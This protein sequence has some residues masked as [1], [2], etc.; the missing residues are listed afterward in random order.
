MRLAL[1]GASAAATSG[2]RSLGTA[3]APLVENITRL[4]P[5]PVARVVRP[6]D[7]A[8]ICEALA[9]WPGQ[10]SVGGAR[11][12]MGGQIAL[13]D[14]L[15]LDMRSMRSLISLDP[16]TRRARVQAGMRWRDLQDHLDPLGLAVRTMQ[17]YANFTVGGSV[18]VNAHGRYVGHGPIGHSIRALRIVLADGRMIEADR[19]SNSDLFFAAIGGYGALGVIAEVELELDDNSRIERQVAYIPLAEYP[20]WFRERVLPD[21][22]VVLHN[23]DLYPGRF[24]AGP[25]ITWRRSQ[26]PLTIDARL[27][28]DGAKYLGQRSAI[29]AVTELPGGGAMRKHIIAPAQ[30]DHPEVVWRNY[31]ASLDIESLEPFSR[32]MSTYALEEYFVPVRH[33][34]AFL[35]EL[36]R[37]LRKHD[38]EALNVSIRHSPADTESVMA[39]AREEVFC[40]VIYYK[41]RVLTES[42]RR[43]GVWTRQ[44]IDAATAHGGSYY[45]PYQLHATPEQFAAAYPRHAEFRAIKDRYDPTGRFSN[46]MWKK[47]LAGP[48]GGVTRRAIDPARAACTSRSASP[49]GR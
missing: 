20:G 23:V 14:S 24:D 28:P 5:V 32:F 45:L 21:P 7:S 41:Q 11:C 48:P 4:N 16:V 26:Q 42:Q 30:L 27:R 1:F 35:S 40:F 22:D 9:G 34:L 49:S 8:S 46:E 37:I 44:L 3:P 18:S 25:A 33:C 29:W 38:V 12:S 10:V 6:R 2:C 13:R 43:V 39:W 15:H 19:S 47:Y 36:R 31:E 17:S